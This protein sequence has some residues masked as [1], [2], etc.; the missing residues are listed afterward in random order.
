MGAHHHAP[1]KVGQLKRR[2][3]RSAAYAAAEIA[4][5]K[6]PS[7]E[8]TKRDADE[9]IARAE[10]EAESRV[11]HLQA[12]LAQAQQLTEQAMEIDVVIALAMAALPAVEQGMHEPSVAVA[13]I[14]IST[15]RTHFGDH[16]EIN[17]GWHG[18]SIA[19]HLDMYK[20]NWPVW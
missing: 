12:E 20:R 17:D 18:G 16:L 8:R 11:R 15:P 19:P 7:V 4:L 5:A 2:T 6:R 3:N 9:R 14:V 13:Q 1:L 10:A